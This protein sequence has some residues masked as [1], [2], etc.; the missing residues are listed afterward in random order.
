MNGWGFSNGTVGRVFA[1][2][3]TVRQQSC[4]QVCGREQLGRHAGRQEVGRCHIRGEYQET[5]NIYV[6]AK[7]K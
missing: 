6:S 4:S 3:H 5:C 1:W 2:S 7:H